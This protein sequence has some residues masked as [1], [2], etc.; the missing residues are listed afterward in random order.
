[1][2]K[3]C[4]FITDISRSGGTERVTSLLSN[5]L[6]KLNYDVTIL[7]VYKGKKSYFR[8]NE[9]IKLINLFDDMS[10]R[11]IKNLLSYGK[12]RK[13][14][15]K[16]QFDY[17]LDIDV[18]LSFTSIPALFNLKTK[19]I[20]CE[21]FNFYS[22]DGKKRRDWARNLAARYS[23]YIVTLTE[24]DKNQYLENLNVKTKIDFIYN[25]TPYPNAIKSECKTKIAIAV[26]RLTNIKGF[27]KLLNIWSEIEKKDSEWKLFIIGSGEDKEKL[28]K[29]ME[30]LKIKRAQIIE[31]T[32][33]IEEYYKKASIYLM[34]SRYEGLPMT[35]I[36]AQSFGIPIISYDIKTG[37]RDIVVNSKNGYLIENDN[38]V[39]FVNKFIEI[40]NDPLKIQE[41]SKNS[42]EDSKRFDINNIIAK[43]EEVLN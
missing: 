14:V 27:D 15:K 34:T 33:S 13:I 2:K 17:I 23:D 36:E 5:E 3:I 40:S 29:Q 35:L 12:L 19:I 25:P 37:P 8:L 39:E 10:N 43:W 21:H 31:H 26:G 9:K 28:L 41:F 11:P 7:S 42:Y 20:S 16:N 18:V 22:N 1:M 4:F 24:Q 30:L 38:E 6:I 32:K